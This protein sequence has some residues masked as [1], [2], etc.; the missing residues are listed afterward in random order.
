ML[1]N[2]MKHN[3]YSLIELLFAVAIMGILASTAIVLIS[4][5]NRSIS[6]KEYAER[7]IAHLHYVQETAI[8]N[9]TY[10]SLSIVQSEKK[11]I[12]DILHVPSS[13]TETL[14][15]PHNGNMVPEIAIQTATLT[16]DPPIADDTVA[17]IFSPWGLYDR[18]SE[19]T[20]TFDKTTFSI[21][22]IT[23]FVE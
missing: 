17:F 20:L 21:Y 12:A 15:L 11:Y 2:Q 4:P 10:A 16:I 13:S 3:G 23:G 6:S 18:E 19:L 7:F 9:N 1:L 5:N 14:Q 8:A 22:G